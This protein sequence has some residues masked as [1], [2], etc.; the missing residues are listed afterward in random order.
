MNVSILRLRRD[1]GAACLLGFYV[2]GDLL[3]PIAS[4]ADVADQPNAFMQVLGNALP[5]GPWI[6][7]ATLLG[8]LLLIL[9][10]VHAARFNLGRPRPHWLDGTMLLWI[11][12][13]MLVGLANDSP[14]TK[15]VWDSA[16]LALTWGTVY[17]A[18][19]IAYQRPEDLMDCLWVLVGLG[20]V[21]LAVALTEFVGGRFWYDTLYGFHPFYSQGESRYFGYRPLLMF[22]DPNQIAMWWTTVAL[23]SLTL[24]WSRVQPKPPAWLLALLVVPPF[25]FQA[26]GGSLLTLFGAAALRLRGRRAI[27]IAAMIGLLVLGGLFVFRGPLLQFGRQFVETSPAG[28]AARGLLRNSS[29]GSFAW[30]L[31]LEEKNAALLRERIGFGWGDVNFW[32]VDADSSRPW[33]LATLITGAYG[34]VGF[35]IWLSLALLPCA[36]VFLHGAKR[37]A[38]DGWPLRGVAVIALVHA[39][40]A[41]MNSAYWLPV[42]FCIGMMNANESTRRAAQATG[43]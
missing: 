34:A 12:T 4:F 33:G 42:V 5:Y 7:R 31:G 29:L 41:S 15:A 2:A 39:I 40:D 27:A 32:R 23:A 43:F 6:N 37:S 20:A 36:A 21:S 8:P 14:W 10:I 3:L 24:L 16:Y 19:R 28:Q 26:V 18:G 13:P 1:H 38:C 9:A 35:G 11:L 30:R 22:E 25:W 17:A